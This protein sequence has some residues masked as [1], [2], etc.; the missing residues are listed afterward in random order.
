MYSF[1]YFLFLYDLT[2]NNNNELCLYTGIE[3][4]KLIA[5]ERIDGI[6]ISSNEIV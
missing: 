1:V 3:L 6:P 2:N 4:I 5:M